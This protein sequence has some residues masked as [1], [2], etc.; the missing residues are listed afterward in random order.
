MADNISRQFGPRSGPTKCL[1]SFFLHFFVYFTQQSRGIYIYT[2]VVRK[3]KSDMSRSSQ[4]LDCFHK[5][6]NFQL[7]TIWKENLS[8]VKDLS[9]QKDIQSDCS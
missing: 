2:S 1:M 6:S 7:K 9:L 5:A 8:I 4:G 3:T